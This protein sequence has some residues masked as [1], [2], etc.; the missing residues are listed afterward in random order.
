M[1]GDEDDSRA[2]E[3]AGKE[4]MF[5][6]CPDELVGNAES[7]EAVSAVGIEEDMGEKHNLR[8]ENEA[9]DGF[10]AVDEVEHLR[11]M[12]DKTIREKESVSRQYEVRSI[13]L[14]IFA[15]SLKAT[16]LM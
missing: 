4:D 9:P 5:V 12:L 8:E 16:L 11:T 13:V 15:K 7:K 1:V 6:D 3:D 2:T 10:A 14:V